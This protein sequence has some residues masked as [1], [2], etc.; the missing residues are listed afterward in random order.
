MGENCYLTFPSNLL[1]AASPTH[2]LLNHNDKLLQKSQITINCSLAKQKPA[3]AE[4][5]FLVVNGVS[6]QE[7]ELPILC[8]YHV[9]AAPSEVHF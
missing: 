6:A 5:Q 1:D 2:H 9:P 4:L 7:L 3:L 8:V